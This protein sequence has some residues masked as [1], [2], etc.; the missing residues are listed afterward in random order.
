[1]WY[2]T[3]NVIIK[4]DRMK[5]RLNYCLLLFLLICRLGF[6]QSSSVTVSGIVTGPDG[7]EALPGV[8]ISVKN[9]T[10]ATATG[11]D[12]KY[13]LTAPANGVL[14]FSFMGYEP[15][16]VAVKGKTTIDV[17]LKS[18]TTLLND[19]VVVG[20]TQQSKAKTTAAISKLN[21]EE[22]RNT[23]NPNPVQAMQGKIA[24]V[25]IPITSGQPGSGAGNIII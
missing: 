12:G 6:S 17:S 25:S 1:M 18:S 2:I 21:V 22:L 24:G 3:T 19:V 8:T 13:S 16:E 9:T 7:N 10:K 23:S 14:I 20:Y 11:T 15:R 4:T 5:S